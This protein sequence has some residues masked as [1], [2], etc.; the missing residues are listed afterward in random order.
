MWLIVGTIVT[1]TMLTI[2]TFSVHRI[3]CVFKCQDNRTVVFS[4]G[5]VF[6]P[7]KIILRFQ[8]GQHKVD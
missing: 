2:I 5:N 1:V 3:F 4:G 8:E 7:R 6:S